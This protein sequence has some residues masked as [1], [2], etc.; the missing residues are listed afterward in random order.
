M[1]ILR[2]ESGITHG[3]ERLED[4]VSQW[5]GV[6]DYE[7]RGSVSARDNAGLRQLLRTDQPCGRQ[8]DLETRPT[9]QLAVHFN[10][11]A[12]LLNNAVNRCQ[13]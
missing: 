11:S 10:I 3:L 1:T 4:Q 2:Q 7:D 8:I 13:S 9:A 12:A 5:F 6:F